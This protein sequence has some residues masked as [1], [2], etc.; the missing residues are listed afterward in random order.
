[1]S[2][3]LEELWKY[4]TSTNEISDTKRTG[5]AGEGL[6]SKNWNIFPS[7][8]TGREIKMEHLRQ[9]LY[10]SDRS[11]NLNGAIIG[12]DSYSVH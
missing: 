5:T 9:L 11:L 3:I 8:V 10:N 12:F 4:P 6:L 2:R 1:M 7:H